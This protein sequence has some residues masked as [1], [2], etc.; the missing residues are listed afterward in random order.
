MR[1]KQIATHKTILLN[2]EDGYQLKLHVTDTSCNWFPTHLLL[3]WNLQYFLYKHLN[4]KRGRLCMKATA[5]DINPQQTTILRW[6][7]AR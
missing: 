2:Q 3:S 5:C 6:P 4:E 7:N 1:Q